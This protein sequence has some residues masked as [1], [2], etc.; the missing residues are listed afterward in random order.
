MLFEKIPK[1]VDFS[2]WAEANSDGV[3]LTCTFFWFLPTLY[4]CSHLL[5][6]IQVM[7]FIHFRAVDYI[8]EYIHIV[9][10][11]ISSFSILLLPKKSILRSFFLL[12]RS[13]VFF[14][15]CSEIFFSFLVFHLKCTNSAHHIFCVRFMNRWKNGSYFKI[16][17]K[18]RHLL[19]NLKIELVCVC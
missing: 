10:K 8:S 6:P 4:K 9:F 13:S 18:I 15:S 2:L 5:T 12:A 7:N 1:Y 11:I 19:K 14:K 3:S 17:T 16:V